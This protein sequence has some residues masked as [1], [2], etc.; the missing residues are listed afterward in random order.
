MSVITT[1]FEPF[2]CVITH[3]WAYLRTR[4]PEWC[5]IC[6]IH[7]PGSGAGGSCGPV[8]SSPGKISAWCLYCS[9]S[10]LKSSTSLLSS[11]RSSDFISG[12]IG[13][14]LVDRGDGVGIFGRLLRMRREAV[15]FTRCRLAAGQK[16]DHLAPHP[17]PPQDMGLERRYCVSNICSCD[18]FTCWV[19]L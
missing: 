12:Q 18:V 6:R 17:P 3:K 15:S 4:E 9:L 5:P 11:A 2:S 10:A 19:W 16:R 7:R 13:T 1:R 8:Y 14:L